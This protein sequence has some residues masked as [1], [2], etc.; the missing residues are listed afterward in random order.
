MWVDAY[1][2]RD[3]RNGSR[4]LGASAW[5]KFDDERFAA[6]FN[7]SQARGDKTKLMQLFGQ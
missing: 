6:L 2:I 4:I 1:S 7:E 5:I 3:W